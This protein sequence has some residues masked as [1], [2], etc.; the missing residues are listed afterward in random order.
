[1]AW[2]NFE[3]L[4]Y[5]KRID[6]SCRQLEL[7]KIELKRAG[8][9]LKHLTANAFALLDGYS[10]TEKSLVCLLVNILSIF[11]YEPPLRV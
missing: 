1:L 8:H 3:I 6:L 9:S 5:I 10:D 2:E 4:S 7:M 11:Q